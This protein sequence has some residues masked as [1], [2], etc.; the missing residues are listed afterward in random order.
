MP[1][2]VLCLLPAEGRHGQKLRTPEAFPTRKTLPVGTTLT[3]GHELYHQRR[4]GD[5]GTANLGAAIFLT[6]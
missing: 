4:V 5:V 1:L 6:F 3:I 2:Q